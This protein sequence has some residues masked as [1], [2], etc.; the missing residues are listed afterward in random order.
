VGHVDDNGRRDT[1]NDIPKIGRWLLTAI[2]FP[3]IPTV[4]PYLKIS[5]VGLDVL[6]K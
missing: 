4:S 6:S 5:P 2:L 3:N 1:I